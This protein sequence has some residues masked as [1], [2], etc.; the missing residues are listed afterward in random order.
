M[1]DRPITA[2][3]RLQLH[4]GFTFSDARRVVPYLADLGVS[5][6]YLS[7][8]LQAAPGSMHG[9]DVVDH[10]VVSADLGGREGLESLADHAHQHGLGVVV[11][12]VPNHMAIPQPEH[13]NPQLWDV[14][15]HGR[16]SAYAHW[17]DVDWDLCDG[18]LGLPVLGDTL[19]AVLAAGELTLEPAGGPA[20]TPVIRYHDHVF[21]VAPETVDDTSEV[22]AVLARQHYLLASWRDKDAVLGYRRFFDVDTLIAVRVELD[23][24]FDETHTVLLDLHANGVIAGFRIDHPDGLADPEAYLERLAEVSGGAWVVVEKI[25]VGREQLPASWATAGSTGYD[26]L[27]AI[28]TALAPSTGHRLDATWRALGGDPSLHDTELAAKRQVVTTMLAPEVAR[29]TRRA[30]EMSEV[31]AATAR[32]TSDNSVR[33]A[34]EALLSHVEVYRA[35]LRPGT[36]PDPL[37]LKRLDIMVAAAAVERPDLADTL[38]VLRRVLAD[39]DSDVPAVRDVVIRFQQVCGPA[40]AKAVEDTTFYRFNR[41]LALNE[42]GGDPAVLDEPG[43]EHLHAWAGQELQ[44]H[45]RG[46]TALSTHDTKRSE[47]VRA[48]LLALAAD[49]TAWDALWGEVAGRAAGHV[50]DGPTAYLLFQTMLG[51]WPIDGERLAAYLVKAMREA[52]RHTSWNDPDETYEGRVLDLAEDCLHDKSLSRRIA[53]TLEEHDGEIAAITLGAKLLQLTLPGVPDVYQGCE[54]VALSLVDPDNRRPVDFDGLMARLD[55]LDERQPDGGAASHFGLADVKLHLTA[56]ALRLRRDRPELFGPGSTYTPLPSSPEVID[57]TRGRDDGL[58]ATV[59]QTTAGG[60]GSATLEL[61]DGRWVDLLSQRV[62]RGGVLG[63]E[64]F[65]DHPVALLVQ[66]VRS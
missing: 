5:H 38:G 53:E 32:S 64:V 22:G 15:T 51:A 11:D 21:P 18:R 66:E 29:L 30:T 56:T 37:S 35:Y 33:D 54:S 23:D 24:V 46:L 12:V 25:L 60:P 28:S 17:F 52:K 55:R 39:V 36:P 58:V 3:Y 50:V 1:S 16:S 65:G 2:T 47:D 61:P 49:V 41:M 43:P 44:H 45:P 7:P 26:A 31:Q 4:E 6:L 27:S 8:V 20:G 13:L 14:L 59:V 40:M 63:A 19:D 34:F 62:H 10:S 9:Y 57:Y 42:V 48:R